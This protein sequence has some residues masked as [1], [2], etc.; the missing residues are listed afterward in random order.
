MM[1]LR[2]FAALALLALVPGASACAVPAAGAQV[3]ASLAWR[4]TPSEAGAARVQF[5]LSYRTANSNSQYGHTLDLAELQGLDRAALDGGGNAPVRFRLVR[6]AGAFDCEGAAWHG[7]GTG[8]CRFVPGADFA[9][10]LGRRGY[11]TPDELQLFRLAMADI[12][13]A[14][15]EMLAHQDYARPSVAEL[16]DAGDHGVNLHYLGE[17]GAL[18]YHV[19]TLPAL[20]RMRDHGVGPDYVRSV[21]TAGLRDLPPDTLVR[22]RDHGVSAAYIG[23]LRRLGYGGLGVERLIELRDHGVGADYVGALSR[24][25]LSGLSLEDLVRL[26]DHGVSADYVAG[27]REAGYAHFGPVEL[28]R[29]RDNGVSGEFVR[30]VGGGGRLTADELIRLRTGG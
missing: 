20:I 12:G 4:I 29:L 16:V 19:G 11:G 6:D 8:T 28:V 21:V 5:E 14:Y 17:M 10:E 13:R 18:G 3:P 9:V 30:R 1:R 2:F 25:G 23:E 26:R 22:M 24:S 15:I 27:L 7:S